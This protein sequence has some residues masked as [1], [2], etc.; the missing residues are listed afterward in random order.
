MNN[1]PFDSAISEYL[2][3]FMAWALGPGLVH[4]LTDRGNSVNFFFF[5]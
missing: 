4:K 1:F 2:G 3:G 5:L